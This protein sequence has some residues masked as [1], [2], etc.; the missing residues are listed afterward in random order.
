MVVV[1]VRVEERSIDPGSGTKVKVENFNQRYRIGVEVS[2]TGTKMYKRQIEI[3]RKKLVP[4][5]KED[6]TETRKQ[7]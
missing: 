5:V 6:P 7:F 2:Q 4:L 3:M 1:M